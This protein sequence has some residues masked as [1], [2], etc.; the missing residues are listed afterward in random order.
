MSD[1]S[2]EFTPGGERRPMVT[3]APSAPRLR[4]PALRV[5]ERRIR[6]FL[7]LAT[8]LLSWFTASPF[9]NLS[10]PAVLLPKV[11]GDML[12]QAATLSLTAALAAFVYAQRSVLIWRVATLT[13]LLTFAAFALSA[14]VSDYPD[15]ALRRL[16]LA[17]MTIFQ[18][19]TLLLLPY[20]REHFA[21]L[22][23]IAAAV[24]LATC[25]FGVAFLPRLSI[26]QASDLA[27]PSLAGD[28][29]GFFAHKNGAGAAMVL[30]IFIGVFVARSWKRSVGI[31]IVVL[32]A[33][34]LKFTHS[35]SP[36][37]LL[38]AVLALSYLLPRTRSSLAAFVLVVC[39]P[40][41]INLLTIG[42]VMFEPVQNFVEDWMS[43]PTFTGRTEIWRFAIDHVAQRPWFGFGF[44][45]FWGMPDLVEKWSYA[46]SWGYRASDAHNAYLN[47]AVTTG[48]VGL[49]AALSWIILQ[50]FCDWRRA[51]A[52][53]ADPAL[54]TLFLQFW[55]FGLCLGGFESVLF[56]GG[57]CVWFMI[58]AAIVGFRFQSIANSA[59]P[60]AC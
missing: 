55:I 25:Y 4:M 49:G 13:L 36:I 48:I 47:L 37:N 11:G 34:F 42:S 6:E 20:D 17:A 31:A 3:A 52:R 59:G 40:L 2:I 8:F 58:A 45:S 57:S 35:K 33:V 21:R 22:L 19:A 30:L 15:V 46:E 56:S 9:P 5:D 1:R 24:V 50:A 38:P 14:L 44:E 23:A 27:E 7:F 32:A 43:D 60:A 28:W 10:D 12:G 54:T 51:A 16:L 18:A 53:A 41:A 39:T 29:R 26:H